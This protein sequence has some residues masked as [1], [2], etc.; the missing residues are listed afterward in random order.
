MA[1][2]RKE[3]PAFLRHERKKMYARVAQQMGGGPL[4]PRPEGPVSDSFN[5]EGGRA[6]PA[7]G[8][9][10]LQAEPVALPT[11]SRTGSLM[12]TVTELSTSRARKSGSGPPHEVTAAQ[13]EAILI[14]ATELFTEHGFRKV[15]LEEIASRAGVKR[16]EVYAMCANKENLFFQVVSVEVETFVAQGGTWV[17]ASAP[18]MEVVR[19]LPE[20]AFGYL[21]GRPLLLQLLLGMLA[22]QLPAW[23]E[24][25]QQLRLRCTEPVVEA[26]RQGVAQ[27]VFREDLQLEAVASLLLEL[28]LA[29]FLVNWSGADRLERVQQRRAAALDLMFRG[30]L[31]VPAGAMAASPAA[32]G[33]VARRR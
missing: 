26:L 24:R 30:L 14:A 20:K 23:D 8:A 18:V 12:W 27:G 22:D 13:R 17:K 15:S 6:A 32:L 9:P 21:D 16:T 11:Q 5:E 29:G 25:F 28:H 19:S 4:R 2:S 10:A 7:T 33:P 3:L 1:Q 31:K